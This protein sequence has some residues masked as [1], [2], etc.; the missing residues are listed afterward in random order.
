MTYSIYIAESAS[1]GSHVSNALAG[2]SYVLKWVTTSG[3]Y[4]GGNFYYNSSLYNSAAVFEPSA[5][6][7]GTNTSGTTT[8]VAQNPA[9]NGDSAPTVY[10]LRSGSTTGLVNATSPTTTVYRQATTP[11][12]ITFSN[13]GS[14]SMT[15]TAS[16]GEYGTMQVRMSSPVTTA[17]T[18]SLPVTYTGLTPGTSH[19]FQARRENSVGT[20]GTRVGFQSTTGGATGSFST[21]SS[22]AISLTSASYDAANTHIAS[23]QWSASPSA[24]YYYTSSQMTPSSGSLNSSAS[25]GGSFTLVAA[26]NTTIGT[27]GFG[28]STTVLRSGSTSGANLDSHITYIYERPATPGAITFSN[29]TDTSFDA[30]YTSNEGNFGSLLVSQY[31]VG[32]SYKNVGGVTSHTEPYTGLSPGT[33]YTVRCY[34]ANN[35]AESAVVTGSVTTTAAADVIPDDIDWAQGGATGRTYS[36]TNANTSTYYQAHWFTTGV[37]ANTDIYWHIET[38]STAH[39]GYYVGGT[40]TWVTNDTKM[41]RQ[42][43]QAGYVRIFSSGDDGTWRGAKIIATTGNDSIKSGTTAALGYFNVTTANTGGGDSGTGGGGTATYGLEVRNSSGNVILGSSNRHGGL[44]ATGAVTNA[45]GG[46]TLAANATSASITVEGLTAS[47]SSTIEILLAGA[48][49]YG[50]A[51]ALPVSRGNGSFTVQNLTS[52]NQTLT[53][54]AVRY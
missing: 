27:Y 51:Y 49:G 33:N 13:V 26:S 45:S 29:V 44:I 4:G 11:T 37:T 36:I 28:Y 54:Y 47:N 19:T 17:F 31:A 3:P 7:T 35:V 38:S 5:G 22:N 42:L 15:V 23:F 41:T 9:N 20:S 50:S 6:N 32:G 48:T 14:T 8:I 34:E 16:G 1:S 39:L 24:L 25:T 53:Y 46:T 43:N 52:T 30:T 2:G 10:T 21:N 18:S 12:A 40:L